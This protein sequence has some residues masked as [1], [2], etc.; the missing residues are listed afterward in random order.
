MLSV[1][2]RPP[3]VVNT[4]TNQRTLLANYA[5]LPP[6]TTMQLQHLIAAGT[7]SVTLIIV[8]THE[9]VYMDTLERTQK[10]LNTFRHDVVQLM[11]YYH[12]LLYDIVVSVY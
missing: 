6:W 2:A 11:L 1:F 9:Y 8:H 5:L 4:L 10:R 12:T 3:K 7:Y